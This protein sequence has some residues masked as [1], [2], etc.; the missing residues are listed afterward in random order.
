LA[1]LRSAL[2]GR[3]DER[4]YDIIVG[5]SSKCKRYYRQS[6]AYRLIPEHVLFIVRKFFKVYWDERTFDTK[7][8]YSLMFLGFLSLILI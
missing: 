7:E 6:Y 8:V 1:C 2:T 4:Y 5:R 3:S